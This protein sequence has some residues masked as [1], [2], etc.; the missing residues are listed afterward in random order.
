M[1]LGGCQVVI[2]CDG[3][4]IREV[5]P[6]MDGDDDKAI[7][8]FIASQ[9]GKVSAEVGHTCGTS[10]G[11]TTKQEFW[12]EYDSNTNNSPPNTELAVDVYF[13]GIFDGGW[14]ARD[15]S[16]RAKKVCGKIQGSRRGNRLHKFTFTNPELVGTPRTFL[17]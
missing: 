17:R 8:C 14:L 15:P 4:T 10:N 13:N 1:K 9:P 5:N 11:T 16:P 7:V 6:R 2:K 3:K 12:I